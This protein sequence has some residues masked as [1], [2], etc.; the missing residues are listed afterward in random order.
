[1]TDIDKA[2]GY[3]YE[4]FAYPLFFHESKEHYSRFL[5]Q[6]RYL[7]TQPIGEDDAAAFETI[8]SFDFEAFKREQND[9]LF[10][11][12]YANIPLTASFYHEGRDNGPKRMAVIDLLKKTP[13]RRDEE[14]SHNVPE[15]YL[16]FIV[17]F[18]A[19]L[20]EG[21]RSEIAGELFAGV[22][23]D[24][25]DEFAEMLAAHKNAVFF[26]AYARLFANFIALERSILGLKAPARP[27]KSVAKAAMEKKPFQSKMPTP[28]SK[29]FWNESSLAES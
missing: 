8:L 13:Y 4:F 21:D 7:A 29:L 26:K 17:R 14:K 27:E 16:G 9:V 28:K 11:F 10:D 23:N 18:A 5:D 22:T 12:S 15:D 20:L 25:A 19:T 24:F 2:R 1:M 3:Y 6:A